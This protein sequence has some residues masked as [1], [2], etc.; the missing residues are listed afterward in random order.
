MKTTKVMLILLV[1][2]FLFVATGLGATA[3]KAG[4]DESGSIETLKLLIADLKKNPDN[5]ELREKLIRHV[6]S[7]KQKPQPSEEFERFMSRGHAYLK[8]A[9]DAAGYSKAIDE[10]KAAVASAP[11]IAEGYESLAEVQEK[12]GIYS[13][14]I[15]N[16]KF[17]LLA[18]PNAKNAREIRNRIYELEVYAEDAKQGAKAAPTV[19]PPPP[20]A[21]PV[22]AKPVPPKKPAPVEKKVNPKA[23]VGSWYYK[24]IAPRGGE[25]ITTHAFTI[26]MDAAGKLAATAP[27]RS[28]GAVGSITVFEIGNDDIHIQVT[29]KLTTIPSYWKTEDYEL[30]L[31]ADET[32]LSGT[33]RIKS[34]GKHEYSE[35]KILFKQ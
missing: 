17:A 4:S 5:V 19:P 16:L 18:D 13:E 35:E 24:D 8:K 29:W 14:A 28:T 30:V 11:W 26:S 9:T 22:A 32:R 10:F 34:S 6:Q 2:V 21:P 1:A 25:E 23:F 12:A 15:V 27:R 20:P 7:M 31:S 33:Y 3:K